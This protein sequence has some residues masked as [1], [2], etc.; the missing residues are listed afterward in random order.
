MAPSHAVIVS[1]PF[2][3]S[4]ARST[5]LLPPVG[6]SPRRAPASSVPGFLSAVVVGLGLVATAFR[7]FVDAEIVNRSMAGSLLCPSALLRIIS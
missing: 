6:R 4:S 3:A 5:V 2:M 1:I 7:E